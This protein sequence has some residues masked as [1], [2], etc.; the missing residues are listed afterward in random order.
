MNR[1]HF[2][3]WVILCFYTIIIIYI[4]V[5][6]SKSKSLEGYILDGRKL[7]LGGFIAT[8]VSTWYGGILGVGE[9]TFLYGIQT[10][11]IFALPYYIF[12]LAYAF[13]IAPKIRKKE[14]LSIPEHF[15]YYYGNNAGIL[16]AFLITFISS[17]AP[18]ILSMGILIQFLFGLNI[19]SALLIATIFSVSYVW[20]GGFSSIVKTDLIQ[21]ILMFL[22]FFLL[23]GFSWHHVGSPIE[24]IKLIPHGHSDPLGGN[25]IQ[26]VLVWFFLAAWTFIDPGFYQRCS[27]A[28]SI[29]VAKNGLLISIGFWAI[30][31]FLTIL[32]G[33][34]SVIL[35][36]TEQPLFSFPMLGQYV[37]PN[38]LFGVFIIGILA[39]IMSTIDSLTLICAFTFGHDILFRIQN[40]ES[41]SSIT[42]IQKGLI[43]VS[44]ISV[45]MAF[46]IPSVVKL[47]YLIGSVL[48]PGIILPFSLTL[49]RDKIFLSEKII[50]QWILIPVITSFIWFSFSQILGQ[51]LLGIEPFY[52]GMFLSFLYFI[53]ILKK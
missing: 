49:I 26:Y 1:F 13:F 30:F 41:K 45:I 9:N 27:A 20:N 39:T 7:S 42:Q 47:F 48:I 11:F 29:K 53:L 36:Q 17:P 25:T 38:G 6:R 3:D 22:G 4:G 34:Y 15:R 51:P 35:I 37:L 2:I 40:T 16:C 5:F 44:F 43:I 33:L 18:Y 28:K 23:I 31:D 21:F 50:I 14:F 24:L 32:C 52:P 19:G 8:L 10:W 12:A 46:F